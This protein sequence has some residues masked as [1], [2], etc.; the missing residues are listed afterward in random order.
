MNRALTCVLAACTTVVSAGCEMS[1]GV[2]LAD[3]NSP[4]LAESEEEMRP[5]D[6]AAYG[7]RAGE[8]ASVYFSFLGGSGDANYD[9]VLLRRSDYDAIFGYLNAPS[10]APD[11]TLPEITPLDAVTQIGMTSMAG[12]GASVI[13]P[14]DYVL[15]IDRTDLFTKPA[16]SS[17]YVLEFELHGLN[18]EPNL[19]QSS[20]D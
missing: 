7:F 14:G 10:S 9:V 13:E 5:G 4:V 1:I 15:L 19:S 12:S 16:S 3:R 11:P 17:A 2:P 8:D 18:C 20:N 6:W